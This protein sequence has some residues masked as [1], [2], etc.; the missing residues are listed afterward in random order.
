MN[1]FEAVKQQF[2]GEG[3]TSWHLFLD[4]NAPKIDP[5][6][7]NRRRRTVIL[8]SQD[9]RDL[10]DPILSKI[11]ALILSQITAANS[12]FRQHVINVSVL[13]TS[14]G[15]ITVWYQFSGS[16]SST[17]TIFRGLEI[18]LAYHR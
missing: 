17:K 14:A 10:Y 18:G 13:S 9:L 15:D 2:D 11:F 5:T 6:F 16:T 3:D 8:R 12:K 4:V 7:F 1:L